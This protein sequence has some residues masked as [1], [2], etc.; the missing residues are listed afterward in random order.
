MARVQA[1]TT[2]RLQTMGEGWRRA[3]PISRGWSPSG[4]SGL[5][6]DRSIDG[7]NDQADRRAACRSCNERLAVID[8]AQKNLTELTAQVTSLRDVLANKQARGAF[9]QGRME[10]IV[11]EACPR[12]LRVPVHALEQHPAR[13]RGL[14]AGPAGRW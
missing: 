6:P 9:G 12:A 3:S 7:G 2:G 4:S 5:G 10:A 11:Q 13:L 1:E 14:P 8:S